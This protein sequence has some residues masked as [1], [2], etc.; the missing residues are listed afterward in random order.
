MVFYKFKLSSYDLSEHY[1][2]YFY[3]DYNLIKVGVYYIKF[4]LIN[5]RL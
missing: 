4:M 2:N 1:R 5:K 3:N